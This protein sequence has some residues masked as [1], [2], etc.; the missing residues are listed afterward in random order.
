[1]KYI[2]YRVVQGLYENISTEE[3]DNLMGET[4]AYMNIIH[5]SYSLLAARIAISSLH[6]S[7]NDSFSETI[8]NLYSYEEKGQAASLISKDVY[9]IVMRNKV[10]FLL[11]EKIEKVIDHSR[12]FTYD[13]FGFKTI[14]KSYL[15]KIH[16]KVVERP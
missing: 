10:Y 3:I 4:C 13:F 14:E 7:T 12:D 6:K 2:V 5:P 11:K 9:D 15:L 1:M 16:G 8:E